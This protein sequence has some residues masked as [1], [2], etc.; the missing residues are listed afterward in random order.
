MRNKSMKSKHLL[1]A[2]CY[3]LS[4]TCA[5]LH[6]AD[7]VTPDLKAIPSRKGWSLTPGYKAEVVDLKG[8]A[9]VRIASDDRKALGGA[10]AR[11]EG[12]TL[13]SGEIEVDILAPQGTRS[14][15]VGIAFRI[16]DE[17]QMDLVYFRPQKFGQPKK[18]GD[19]VGEVQYSS[20]PKYGWSRLRNTFP[21]KYEKHLPK[22]PQNQAAWFHARI[23]VEGAK[24]RVYVDG[25]AEPC[26][27]VEKSLSGRTQ[28]GVGLWT[29]SGGAF[30]NLKIT[31]RN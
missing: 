14:A 18:T 11:L 5:A 6:G 16:Q 15:F 22:A 28:G 17:K 25:A 23:V 20:E 19:L 12:M 10:L 3:A 30:A 29:W 26:L 27:A 31:P 1:A 4:L 9:A 2:L 21:L 7:I 8:K 13:E 24:V